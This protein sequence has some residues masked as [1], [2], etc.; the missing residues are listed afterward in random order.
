M[1]KIEHRRY[2]D[3][4]W[5]KDITFHMSKWGKPFSIFCIFQSFTIWDELYNQ[6]IKYTANINSVANVIIM[7]VLMRWRLYSL[8]EKNIWISQH[9][10]CCKY[11]VCYIFV[12]C[13]TEL[14]LPRGKGFNLTVL[15]P[16]LTVG[17]HLLKATHWYS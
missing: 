1:L 10:D 9:L 16:D 15:I 8:I 12:S 3:T 7:A 4:K 14:N 5:A 11:H 6:W 17:Q 2:G 13:W